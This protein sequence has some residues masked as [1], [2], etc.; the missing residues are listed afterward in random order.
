M[1]HQTWSSIAGVPFYFSRS[2]FNFHGHTAKKIVILTQIG[3][4]RTVTSVWIHQWLRND[5][6]SLRYHR[7]CALLSFQVMRQISS[8]HRTKKF[9]DFDPNRAFP[10]CSLSLNLPMDLMPK[11]WCSIEEVPYY[12]SEVIHQISRSHRLKNLWFE[13]NLSEITRPIAVIKSLRFSLFNLECATLNMILDC[14]AS[15][16]NRTCY[17]ADTTRCAIF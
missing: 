7:R 4:F 16:Q 13:S 15:I 11:A 2:S 8:S 12:F 10:D 9:P 14:K 1:M 17:R 5:A 3:R 6:L